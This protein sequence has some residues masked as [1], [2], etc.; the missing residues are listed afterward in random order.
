VQSETN[1]LLRYGVDAGVEALDGVRDFSLEL[2]GVK[3]RDENKNER[4]EHL[5]Q[6]P[7]EHQ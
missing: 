3:Q 1:P 2:H 6:H 7:L 4:R 5:L